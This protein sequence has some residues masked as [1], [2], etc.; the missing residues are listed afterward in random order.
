MDLEISSK[1]THFFLV[2]KESSP[3]NSTERLTIRGVTYTG[4]HL[5]SVIQKIDTST[6]ASGMYIKRIFMYFKKLFFFFIIVTKT[7]IFGKYKK[8]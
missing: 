3:A 2:L 5:C 4:T 1:E 7:T 8:I 6:K